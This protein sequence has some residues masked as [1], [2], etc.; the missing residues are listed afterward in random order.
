M[1]ENRVAINAIMTAMNDANDAG[2]QLLPYTN[3]KG[4]W[5]NPNGRYEYWWSS[6]AFNEY[7]SWVVYSDGGIYNLNSYN[8]NDVRAVSAFHFEY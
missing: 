7:C 1:Q 3:D 8:T 5:V 6:T 4:G 2:F